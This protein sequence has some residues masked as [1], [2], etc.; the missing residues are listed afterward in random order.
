MSNLCNGTD[1]RN[2]R[3]TGSLNYLTVRLAQLL[4][5]VM[6]NGELLT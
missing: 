3:L 2:G 5:E 1:L 4:L 6:I